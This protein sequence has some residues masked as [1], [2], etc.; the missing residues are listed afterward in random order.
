LAE[1]QRDFAAAIL[2]KNEYTIEEAIEAL[3]SALKKG[4]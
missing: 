1:Y 4:V 3:D 2:T